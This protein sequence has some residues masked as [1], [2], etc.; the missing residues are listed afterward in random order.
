MPATDDEAPGKTLSMCSSP[1]P[2]LFRLGLRAVTNRI[3]LIS[4]KTLGAT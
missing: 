1:R 2:R 4:S 3:W